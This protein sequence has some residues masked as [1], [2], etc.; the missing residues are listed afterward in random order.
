MGAWDP[1]QADRAQCCGRQE[2]SEEYIKPTMC[3]PLWHRLLSLIRMLQDCQFAGCSEVGA[4]IDGSLHA[5]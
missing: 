5:M 3:L 1:V 2:E 4:T